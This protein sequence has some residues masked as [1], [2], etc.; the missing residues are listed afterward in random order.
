M[1]N[2]GIDMQ[3][4]ICG[5]E[6]VA[7]GVHLRRKHKIAPA[8]YKAE[9]GMLLAT[10][11]VDDWLSERIRSSQKSRM[12]DPEYKA[13]V[14]E[15]CRENAAK[16][17]GKPSSGM[18]KAGKES[19]ALHDKARNKKYLEAQSVVVGKVLKEKG[20]MLD[21]R[22]ATGTGPVAGRKMAVIAGVPYTRDSAKAERDKRAAA[23]T[24]AKALVRVAKVMP[25]FDTTKSAAE[26]CRLGGVSIKTYKN[27]LAAG[28]IARHPNGRGP[29][30]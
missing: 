23:T 7:L 25:H 14:S 29:R 30:T 22:R 12:E 6:Y 11:L 4:N 2:K 26:M 21:V 27:W 19:I 9:Y 3:C 5:R 18:T 1:T 24:R 10:P 17:V 28:L 16:N 8:E 20:T 13:E 15:R